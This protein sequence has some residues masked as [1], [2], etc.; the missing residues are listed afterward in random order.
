MSNVITTGVRRGSYMWVGGICGQ[1]R[2]GEVCPWRWPRGVGEI[3]EMSMQVGAGGLV[4]WDGRGLGGDIGGLMGVDG[5]GWGSEV[6]SGFKVGICDW[7]KIFSVRSLVCTDHL[8]VIYSSLYTEQVID[9]TIKPEYLAAPL[10]DWPSS[11]A[12]Q[13]ASPWSGTTWALSLHHFL[14]KTCW[15][16]SSIPST[17]SCS[18]LPW[19]SSSS[20]RKS[21]HQNETLSLP[22]RPAQVFYSGSSVDYCFRDNAWRQSWNSYLQG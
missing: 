17:E 13:P 12:R 3:R 4:G 18:P 20:K 15:T 22:S 14:K 9:C 1:E 2:G 7:C 5:H 21:P 16:A 6:A 11:S 8:A 10:I 19:I